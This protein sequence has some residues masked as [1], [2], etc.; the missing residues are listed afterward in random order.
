[1]LLKIV[2][3]VANYYF[4]NFQSI[5]TFSGLFTTAIF[6]DLVSHTYVLIVD[7]KLPTVISLVYVV[8]HFPTGSEIHIQECPFQQ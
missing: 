2:I 3:S 1:M 4:F 7:N 5:T 8:T 6:W